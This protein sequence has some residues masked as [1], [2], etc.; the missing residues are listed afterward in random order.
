[1]VAGNTN[2][3]QHATTLLRSGGVIAYPT[4]SVF[5]LGCLASLPQS[6]ERLLAIKGRDSSKGLIVAGAELAHFSQWIE[7]LSPTEIQQIR[8]IPHRPTTW[9]VRAKKTTS[10]LLTGNSSLLA[11]R[12]SQHP[13]IQ[14]FCHELGEG[15]VSTS[16][17]LSGKSPAR[18]APQIDATLA[19]Q[20]DFIVDEACGDHTKPSRI[21]DLATGRVL[22]E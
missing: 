22:R 1:M 9:L 6:I 15:I 2:S 7:P 20:L 8:A 5:G 10:T 12:I 21:C 16:A 19:R 3:R 14:A 18:H 11:I 17:N 13:V 4:E